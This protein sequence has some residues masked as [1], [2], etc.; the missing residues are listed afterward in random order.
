MTVAKFCELVLDVD[1]TIWLVTIAHSYSI[2]TRVFTS[3]GE[4]KTYQQLP[5]HPFPLNKTG[6]GSKD[7]LDPIQML[8]INWLVIVKKSVNLQVENPVFGLVTS[9]HNQSTRGSMYS[10]LK[11]A[12]CP[13]GVICQVQF[14]AEKL[15]TLLYFRYSLAIVR[16]HSSISPAY[17]S[18]CFLRKG[19][20]HNMSRGDASYTSSAWGNMVCFRDYHNDNQLIFSAE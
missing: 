7:S 19:M 12:T 11:S 2:S 1:T 20:V 5:D 6:A 16:Q 13:P 8:C 18:L 3:A 15:T 14:L 17:C 10:T 9:S 4:R